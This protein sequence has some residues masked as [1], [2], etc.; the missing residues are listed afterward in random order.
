MTYDTDPIWVNAAQCNGIVTT[1]S[2]RIAG[3]CGATGETHIKDL[4]DA[5]GQLR[6]LLFLATATTSSPRGRRT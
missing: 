3:N 5:L 1:V 2:I 4:A 6:G